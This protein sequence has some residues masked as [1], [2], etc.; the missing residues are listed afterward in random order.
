MIKLEGAS[1]LK[2]ARNVYYLPQVEMQLI[3]TRLHYQPGILQV[4]MP[5]G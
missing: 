2:G 5:E 1:L 3:A 4:V